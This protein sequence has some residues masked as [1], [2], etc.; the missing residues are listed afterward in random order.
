LPGAVRI[1]AL[2]Q[3]PDRDVSSMPDSVRKITGLTQ[4]SETS[5]AI[6]GTIPRAMANKTVRPMQ[7]AWEKS[8]ISS[9]KMYFKEASD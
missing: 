6:D 9:H 4:S 5:K 7:K 8:A 3:E 2:K 1:A